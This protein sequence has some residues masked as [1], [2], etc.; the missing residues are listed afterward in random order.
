MELGKLK[1]TLG[2]L[3]DEARETHLK[4]IKEIECG[5][6]EEDLLLDIRRKETQI[7]RIQR[8]FDPEVIKNVYDATAEDDIVVKEI[9]L[10]INEPVTFKF[11]GRDV[12][13]SAYLPYFR[14][15]MNVVPGLPT[16]FTFTPTVT[17]AEMRDIKGEPEF[18][19]HIVCNKICGN[20]HFNMKMKVVVESREDYEKWLREQPTFVSNVDE[21]A[22]GNTAMAL[23]EEVE[24]VAEEVTVN[25]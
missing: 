3:V 15:Q 7:S 6:A 12:I 13:H 8:S 4:K 1:S 2:G 10:P 5:D 17:T 19:Y 21:A 22:E 18:D 9:H 24:V 25:N 14:T 16:Q 11:R 20:A 23:V